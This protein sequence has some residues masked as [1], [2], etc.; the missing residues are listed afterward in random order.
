M[1]DKVVGIRIMDIIEEI[2]IARKKGRKPNF[3]D[4]SVKS[5][6]TRKQTKCY[7]PVKKTRPDSP[8]KPLEDGKETWEPSQKETSIPIK[9]N[10]TVSAPQIA[11]NAS[12]DLSES[13]QLENDEMFN[14]IE[15]SVTMTERFDEIRDEF[16]NELDQVKFRFKEVT[17]EIDT[18]LQVLGDLRAFFN[19]ENKA[20][21]AEIYNLVSE[22][23][24]V[25]NDR[26]SALARS[27][28]G[29]IHINNFRIK[30]PPKQLSRPKNTF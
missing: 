25:K 2:K 15:E 27:Q 7:S 6:M 13:E 14:E 3:Q 12:Q 1:A 20:R 21:S 16:K 5:K 10:Q 24:E 4:F 23:Q 29:I 19:E 18:N 17:K 30:S 8:A 26:F 28:I 9:M 11:V 22:V